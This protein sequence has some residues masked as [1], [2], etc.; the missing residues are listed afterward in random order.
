ML[1]LSQILNY[2]LT[3]SLL[4]KYLFIGLLAGSLPA[5]ADLAKEKGF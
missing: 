2:F 4:V 5:L 3:S 1:V